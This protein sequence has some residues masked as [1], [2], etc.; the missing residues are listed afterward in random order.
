MTIY[1]VVV[2][3]LGVIIGRK[4]VKMEME[5]RNEKNEV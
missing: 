1:T 2:Y 3:A 4:S 5:Q